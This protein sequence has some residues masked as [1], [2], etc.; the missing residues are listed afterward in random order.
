MTD[1][2]YP[3]GRPALLFQ[4]PGEASLRA[5]SWDGAA[6][7]I[8]KAQVPPTTYWTQSPDGSRYVIDTMVYDR[9]GRALGALPWAE[10]VGWA[11]NSQ[12]ACDAAHPAPSVGGPMRLE[13]AAPGQPARV[14]VTGYTTYSDNAGY[15]VLACDATTDRA[16]VASF[17]QGLYAGH[18]WIFRLSTGALVRVADLGQ[19]G[20]GSWVSATT[21]GGLIAEAVQPAVGTLVTTT[22]RRADDGVALGTVADF[23]AHGFSGDGALLFGYS[24]P[25]KRTSQI[26]EWKSGRVVWRATGYFYNGFLTEPGGTHIAVAGSLNNTMSDQDVYIVSPDGTSVLLPK[27]VRTAFR[28]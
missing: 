13:T 8:L 21:D 3:T 7:G 17:G 19:G 4:M 20:V 23:E 1:A 16:I 5:I 24:G 6:T 14:V 11:T 18:L 15:P 9:E 28:Y 10:R 12:F 22:I 27:G 26:V 25:S 2:T